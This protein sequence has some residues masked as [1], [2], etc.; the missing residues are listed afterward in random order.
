MLFKGILWFRCFWP[1]PEFGVLYFFC[2]YKKFSFGT[3]MKYRK[4]NTDLLKQH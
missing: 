3:N 2:V 4:L 1:S